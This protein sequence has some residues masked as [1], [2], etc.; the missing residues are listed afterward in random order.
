MRLEIPENTHPKLTELI[1]RCWEDD[2]TK[3][4]AF[5][6]IAIELECLLQEVEVGLNNRNQLFANSRI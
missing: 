5:S 3:R 1:E 6:S 2:P 4:P